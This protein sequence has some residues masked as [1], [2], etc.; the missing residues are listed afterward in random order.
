MYGDVCKILGIKYPIIQGAMAWI[1]ESNLVAAVSN[2]GGLGVLATGHL[3]VAG[4]RAEIRKLKS[5]TDKPYAVNIM[6][7]SEFADEI[8]ELLCD[9]KVPIITTGAGSPGKYMKMFKQANIKI[10]PVVPSIALAKRAE[11]DGADAVIAEGMESGGHVGKI[12]T[13]SLVPQVADNVSIPVIAAG[14]IADGRGMAAAAMLGASAFQIGTRFLVANE[15]I[16]HDNFKKRILKAKDI[17]TTLT[18]LS[19]G[20]PVRV[21]RNKMA[22]TYEELEKQKAPIEEIEALGK[23]ALRR[24]VLDG[25]MENGSVMSG[26]IAGLVNKEQSCSEIIEE[27][28]GEYV[29]LINNADSLLK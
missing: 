4:C 22:R 26:Q 15:C 23:G 18:G 19:T 9:E 29:S 24:A 7:L 17:D 14:G 5:M 21:I 11:K 25:D 3:D 13:M 27:M 2:A 28:Y 10:L 6:L 20:H 16:V 8:A 12:T 1:A